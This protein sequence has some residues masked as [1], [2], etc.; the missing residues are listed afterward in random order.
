MTDPATI[1][2]FRIDVSQADLDDLRTRLIRTRW[3][4]S[5]AGA[6]WERGVP[7]DYL[8]NLVGYWSREFDWREQEARLNAFPQFTTEIDGQGIHFV[9]LR[10]PES[11]ALPMLIS[12]G[13]PSSIAEF[14]AILGPLADPRAHGGDPKDAFHVIAPTLPGFGFSV[15]LRDRGWHLHRTVDAYAVLM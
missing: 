3:P 9:H 12:H 1:A 13:W 5:L 7:Q 4:S 15:P 14:M 6:G 2:P 10:S 8:Q 11:D